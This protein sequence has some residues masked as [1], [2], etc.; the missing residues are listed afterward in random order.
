MG[1]EVKMTRA[2]FSLVELSIV[3]V[4]LGLLTGGILA[5]QS[6]IRASELRSVTVDMQKYQAAAYTFRDKYFQLPGD[7]NNATSFW[8]FAAGTTGTDAACYAVFST[9]A[10]TCN[11]TGNG[12]VGLTALASP[13]DLV[14]RFLFWKHLANAGLIEGS[15]TGRTNSAASF[16]IVGGTNVPKSKLG[17]G[18]YDVWSVSATHSGNASFFDGT[19]N[20][21]IMLLYGPSTSAYSI[22]KPEEAWNI[23]TKVDDGR[24]A[25]GT[26]IS[27]KSTSPVWTGCT[28]TAVTSTAEYA[29]TTTGNTCGVLWK[30]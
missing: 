11:G 4:I 3:L 12:A 26:I 25:Y 2:G 29:L 1:H 28:T 21:S 6:L 13:H 17:N 7:M 10:A 16:D 9:T 23:D 15:Y 19:Y 22:I 20:T 30:F 8:G 18:Y 5:G 14:E 24:P 27:Y